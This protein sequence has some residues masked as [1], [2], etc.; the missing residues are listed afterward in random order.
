MDAR[1]RAEIIRERASG[2]GFAICRFARVDRAPHAD[3]F[4]RW[5]DRGKHAGMEYLPRTAFTRVDPRVVWPEVRSLIVLGWPYPGGTGPYPRWREELRGRVAAYAAGRDYHRA[6]GEGLRKLADCLMRLEPGIECRWYVDTGPVLERD[7][8]AIAGVGWQGRNTNLLHPRLGSWFFLACILLNRDLEPDAPL[9]DRCGRCSRC[10][11]SCPT[12][13]LS[14]DYELD[15][16][17]CISYWTI[18]HRGSI[19]LRIRPF[20]QD[21]VFG[22]D[23]CQEVCPWNRKRS[24]DSASERNLELYPYLPDILAISESE[25]RQRFRHTA[26]WRARREGLARN[27]AIVLGNSGNPAAIPALYRAL[28]TDPSAVVRCHAAWAMGAIGTGKAVDMLYRTRKR[29]TDPIVLQEINA[30]LEKR[31]ARANVPTDM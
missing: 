5:L 14:E 20:L 15:A 25:F 16:R 26:L 1:R 2:L 11:P 9:P 23:L 30:S 13:A 19:P 8:G 17:L 18:E 12:G 6:V 29:E 27:A 24:I 31:A 22:C 21:W 10:L 4:L 7:W 28:T 3:A